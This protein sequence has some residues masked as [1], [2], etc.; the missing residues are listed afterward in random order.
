MIIKPA[1]D[2]S[3]DFCRWIFCCF[4]LYMLSGNRSDGYLCFK[5]DKAEVNSGDEI[6]TGEVGWLIVDFVGEVVEW[7]AGVKGL[8]SGEDRTG[9]CGKDRMGE[10]RADRMGECGADRTGECGADRTGEFWVVEVPVWRSPVKGKVSDE[11]KGFSVK[12]SITT[13]GSCCWL[14]DVSHF[15]GFRCFFGRFDIVKKKK[16]LRKYLRSV[17]KKKYIERN[18]WEE[19]R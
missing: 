10:C 13:R 9:E 19:K 1:S 14:S 5:L 2:S 11:G 17:K 7:T 3:N 4:S 18:I 16:I 15:K 12:G 6:I 8:A